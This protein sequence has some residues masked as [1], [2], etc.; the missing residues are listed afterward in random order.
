MIDLIPPK[1][2][3]THF[4]FV[5]LNLFIPRLEG[6]IRKFKHAR[7]IRR[8]LPILFTFC[9]LRIRMLTSGSCDPATVSQ[10]LGASM[11]KLFTVAL[12]CTLLAICF[13]PQIKA[14]TT[15]TYT[16][17]QLTNFIEGSCPVQSDP[18]VC[19]PV[20]YCPPICSMDASITFST[21]LGD[22]LNNV[23]VMPEDFKFY[24][25]GSPEVTQTP[26]NSLPL[27]G[28]LGNFPGAFN[29]STNASGQIVNWNLFVEG[30]FDLFYYDTYNRS[31]ICPTCGPFAD[32]SFFGYAGEGISSNMNNPGTWTVSTTAPAVP[33]P[34]TVTLL[35]A[36]LI[37]LSTL[38]LKKIPL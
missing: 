12:F 8:N 32:D 15:Y 34:S 33:E 36:G 9:Y 5:P 19:P 13:T 37:A 24:V 20:N 38:A 7:P 1:S 11:T 23:F 4:A 3:L 29:F 14:D 10:N 26:A 17:N 21:P 22:N 18:R 16:G 2:T 28:P 35:L 31:A 30:D 25:P 6:Q 27:E